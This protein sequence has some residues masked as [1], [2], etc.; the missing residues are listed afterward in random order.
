MT[1]ISLEPL[2]LIMEQSKGL[3]NQQ[4]RLASDVHW[5]IGIIEGEGCFTLSVKNKYGKTKRAYFPMIQ[6]TNSD[7]KM[8][9][10]IRDIFSKLGIAYYFYAQVTKQEIPY[11]TVEIGGIKRIK[12]FLEL[13]LPL[14]RCRGR[15]AEALLEYVNLRL[16]KSNNAPI[17]QQEH[18]VAEKLYNLNGKHKNS[19]LS[20]ETTRRALL[21]KGK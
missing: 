16:N 13:T 7:V 20:S 8:I 21:H 2:P 10:K 14:Y 18:D 5:L 11:F 6:I 15:Q 1:G 9:A 19:S 17:G 3:D 4:E 12:K